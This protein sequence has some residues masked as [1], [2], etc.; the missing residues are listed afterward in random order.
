MEASEGEIQGHQ[1]PPNR[2]ST[3]TTT[4]DNFSASAPSPPF[5]LIRGGSLS[6]S[7]LME[8]GGR[9]RRRRMRHLIRVVCSCS[10]W[11]GLACEETVVVEGRR[12]KKK[13]NS[14][15]DLMERKEGRRLRK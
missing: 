3:Y 12:R 7:E 2:S 8:L 10:R 13:V 14:E 6:A 4:H 5:C 9:R 11:G 15:Q 1:P